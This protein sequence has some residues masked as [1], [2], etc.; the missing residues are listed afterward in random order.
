MVFQTPPSAEE[1]VHRSLV[2]FFPLLSF[3]SPHF[4][5]ENPMR[6]SLWLQT[7]PEVAVSRRKEIFLKKLTENDDSV[8]M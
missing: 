8:E 7:Q 2:D 4:H 3:R 5:D 6:S 1:S